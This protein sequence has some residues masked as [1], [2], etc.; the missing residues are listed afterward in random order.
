MSGV[1]SGIRE[2]FRE[3]QLFFHIQDCQKIGD[4]RN[5]EAN[6]TFLLWPPK[7]LRRKDKSVEKGNG[8]GPAWWR[9]DIAAGRQIGSQMKDG[10]VHA[11]A[12][13]SGWTPGSRKLQWMNR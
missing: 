2:I 11:Y 1:T 8:G 4:R 7:G 9:F 3:V 13:P 6:T 12:L 5:G 10:F